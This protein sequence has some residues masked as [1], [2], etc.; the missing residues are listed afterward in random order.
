MTASPGQARQR[1]HVLVVKLGAFGDIVL[2]D[3]AM[4]DIREHHRDAHIT[5][6]TRTG[7]APLLRRCP[8]ADT[9]L[10]DDNAP[11]WRLDR[12]LALRASCHGR[13]FD[14]GYDLQNS[15]RSRFYR[16]WLSAGS[17]AWSFEHPS[18][19]VGPV[20]GRHAA[21]LRAAGIA[22]N[23]SERPCPDWIAAD[24]GQLLAQAGVRRPF[25]VL[26]PGSSAR[27]LHKRWRQYRD[28]ASHLTRL[29][30][31]V[32][33]I[34]GIEESDIAAGFEGVVLTSDGRVLNLP[35]LAGVLQHASCVVGNDS[36]PTL[37]AAC[38]GTPTVALFASSSQARISTGIQARGAVYLDAPTVAGIT[39]EGVL[40]AMRRQGIAT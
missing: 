24:A 27:H 18:R 6:L 9:I 31:A 29:G 38:L 21:Q 35:E 8:W 26:L 34:P 39:I 36:G 11:R 12:M 17:T 23:W 32:V 19:A 20:P 25:I 37:L 40:D 28:L 10:A 7:Y 4:R 13:T 33:S 15:R 5:L 30:L 22:A 1:E 16:H 2:A 3:G 14:V